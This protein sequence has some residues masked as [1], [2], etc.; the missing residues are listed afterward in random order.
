AALARTGVIRSP[1]VTKMIFSR[2]RISSPDS[3]RRKGRYYRLWAA[4]LRLTWESFCRLPALR[5]WPV[6]QVLF[7]QLYFTGTESLFTI[8]FV[9]FLVGLIVI[10]ELNNLVGS[11]E[12]VTSRVLIWVVVRELGPLIAA[13]VMIGRSSSAFASE[14]STMVV[15]GE[16]KNLRCM[17]ISPLSYLIMPRVLAMMLAGIALA[18]YCQI[19]AVSTGWIVTAM[20]LDISLGDEITSFFEIISYREIAATMLKSAVFGVLV[21][22]VS[23]YHGMRKKTAMTEVTQAVSQAVIRSLLAVFVADGVVTVLVY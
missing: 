11:N 19:V 2:L 8:G 12:S 22:V 9:G 16:I 15:N 6:R 3:R 1:C 20:R 5:R 4:H 10:T 23:V 13:I 17:G 18:F 14:L 7:K 21:A